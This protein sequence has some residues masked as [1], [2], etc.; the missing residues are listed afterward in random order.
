LDEAERERDQRSHVAAAASN[1]VVGAD[2]DDAERDGGL[3]HRGRRRHHIECGERERDAVADGEGGDDLEERLPPSAEQQ[4][5]NQEQDVIGTDEDVVNPRR[6]ERPDHGERATRGPCVIRA[7]RVVVRQDELLPKL[8][9]FVD[10]HERLME[11]IVGEEH[12]VHAERGGTRCA[13]AKA[14]TD[15]LS[16]RN[17]IDRAPFERQRRVGPQHEPL[18][19]E[20][21]NAIAIRG[22]EARFEQP[23]RRCDPQLVGCIDDV[24]HQRAVDRVA[25]LEIQIAERR[26]MAKGRSR[27]EQQ[28]NQ[29]EIGLTHWSAHFIA[30]F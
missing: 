17:R 10:V 6:D 18:G 11:R 3:D 26:G 16:I 9:I 28:A 15:P 13:N 27:S 23:F 29:K 5:T 30:N 25:D 24:N 19:D 12:R 7:I 8:A 20:R 21:S 1:E 22:R 4:Q 14:Q 2:K